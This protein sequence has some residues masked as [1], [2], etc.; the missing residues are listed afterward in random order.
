MAFYPKKE[1]Q[2][3]II[4]DK[5]ADTV[6]GIETEMKGNIDSRGIIRIYGKYTGDI[7][8]SS[9]VIIGE[10]GYVSGNIRADN[11]SI[12]GVVEGNVIAYKLLE[13]K[14]TGKLI[15][16][17]LVRKISLL[18]GAMFKGRSTMLAD[19]DVDSEEEIEEESEQE[20][21]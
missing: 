2:Q 6:I 3:N 12:A 21:N 1:K 15:G 5:I 8:T 4:Q 7:C 17:V 18:E 20:E 10:G 9:D 13:M 16:D 11:I 14:P 19:D